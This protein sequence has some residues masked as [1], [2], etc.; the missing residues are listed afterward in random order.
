MGSEIFAGTEDKGV[1]VSTG[2]GETWIQRDSGFTT[3]VNALVV[4]DSIIFAGGRQC[5]SQEA[6]CHQMR[7]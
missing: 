7:S 1:I 4:K 3:T 5:S 6:S 2:G